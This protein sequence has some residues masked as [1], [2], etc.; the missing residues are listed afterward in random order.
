[1]VGKIVTL[2]DGSEG[3]VKSEHDGMLRVLFHHLSPAKWRIKVV[4]ATC[5]ERVSA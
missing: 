2:H 1:M 5:V 3:L 4:C